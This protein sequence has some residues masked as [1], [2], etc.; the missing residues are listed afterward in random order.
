MTQKEVFAASR[1]MMKG[2]KWR[3]FVLDLSFILWDFLGAITLG[4]V[5]MFYV[6]PYKHL[7]DAALYEVI[8]PQ[9]I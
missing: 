2:N 4:I 6:E 1:A 8:K 9:Q 7:T 3:A 5:S